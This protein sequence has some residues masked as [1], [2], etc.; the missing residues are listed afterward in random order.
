M[1]EWDQRCA[2]ICEPVHKL[3][4]DG[5]PRLAD[6]RAENNSERMPTLDELR[7]DRREEWS[8]S[9]PWVTR[10]GSDENGGGPLHVFISLA[11]RLRDPRAAAWWGTNHRLE[12]PRP[13]HFPAWPATRGVSARA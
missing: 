8:F 4:T 1:P 3:V 5:Q 11:S 12:W 9:V 2:N 13:S 6:S 10:V 7:Q